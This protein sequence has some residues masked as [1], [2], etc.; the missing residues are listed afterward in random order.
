MERKPTPLT[1]Q[2][3]SSTTVWAAVALS[4]LA[5]CLLLSRD[6][7][8]LAE[9]SSALRIQVY[10]DV[11][12]T[13]SSAPA[14]ARTFHQIREANGRLSAEYGFVNFANAPMRITF[15][16]PSSELSDYR[17]AYGYTQADLDAIM[18][19]QKG[20]LDALLQRA[21]KT[22]MNQEELNTE[23]ARI[24]AEARTRQERLFSER[25]FRLKGGKT[26]IPDIPAIARRNVAAVRGVARQFSEGANHQG[27]GKADQIIGSVLA[28]VQT[29]LSYENLPAIKGGRVTGGINPPV[30]AL[31]EGVGD[32][33]S[34]SALLAAILLNWDQVKLIG[35]AVP[36]H[37]LLG[38][39]Q[40]PA[41]GDLFVELEGLRYVLLEPAGPAWLPPGMIAAS[42]MDLLASGSE[43][44]FESL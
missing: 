36:N 26:L 24:Q 3:S 22:G 31:A 23:S 42:T 17:R 29:S 27:E 10:G 5:V 28:M 4:A 11:L 37:Y 16:I 15:T 30:V 43:L 1:G 41:K 32:C 38:L 13:P 8:G 19:W 7:A 18:A 44:R 25:G 6:A 21:V 34:K 20:A 14:G 33:D 12:S 40:N 2:S 9:N 35:I 39:L